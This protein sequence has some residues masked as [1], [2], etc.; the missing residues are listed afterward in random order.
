MRD[1]FSARYR[2]RVAARMPEDETFAHN[3]VGLPG[4]SIHFIVSL[5]RPRSL[6]GAA[7]LIF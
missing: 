4:G 5:Q 7:F 3:Q 6:G 1:N 2:N